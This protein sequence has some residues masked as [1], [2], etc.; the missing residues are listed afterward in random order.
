MIPSHDIKMKE[1]LKK[2][3]K[4]WCI[5]KSCEDK[6][7]KLICNNIKHGNIKK[8]NIAYPQKFALYTG[9]S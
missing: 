2:H 4:P 9:D 7:L 8:K 3:S 1:K 6:L 5:K